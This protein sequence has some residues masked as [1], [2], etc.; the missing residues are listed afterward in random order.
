[1]SLIGKS[2]P[3]LN[4]IIEDVSEQVKDGKAY[5]PT[6][7]VT[8]VLLLISIWVSAQESCE[9]LL[10]SPPSSLLYLRT[11]RNIFISEASILSST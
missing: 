8:V 11:V 6:P 7:W 9:H 1:M 3:K 2:F 5:S 4:T 10:H